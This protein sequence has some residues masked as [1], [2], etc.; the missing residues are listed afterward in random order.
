MVCIETMPSQMFYLKLGQLPSNEITEQVWNQKV[1]KAHMHNS[2]AHIEIC[3]SFCTF[4]PLR[5]TVFSNRAQDTE[6]S[7]SIVGEVW[8]M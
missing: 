2:V 7:E 8:G 4:K 5:Y 1:K 6:F 3:A